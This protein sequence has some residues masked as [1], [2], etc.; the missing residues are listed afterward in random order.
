MHPVGR[1]SLP[2]RPGVPFIAGAH[3]F[4][5][6]KFINVHTAQDLPAKLIEPMCR[7]SRRSFQVVFTRWFKNYRQ[8][9]PKTWKSSPAIKSGK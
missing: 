5:A 4:A 8:G 1:V 7:H 3:G 6:G 9:S 2:V